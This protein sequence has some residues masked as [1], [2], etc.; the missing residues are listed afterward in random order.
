MKKDH[1]EIPSP[2]SKF[3]KLE[4]SECEES[5]IVYSHATTSVSCTHCGNPLATS[6]G[7]KAKLRGK[8]L[9]AVD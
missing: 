3:Y 5:Q 9:G 2:S 4:C 6:T 1:I 8:I 7:S